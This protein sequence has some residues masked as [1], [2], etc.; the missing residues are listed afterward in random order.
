MPTRVEKRIEQRMRYSFLRLPLLEVVTEQIND[1]FQIGIEQ[2]IVGGIEKWVRG[3]PLHHALV[4]VVFQGFGIIE[5]VPTQTQL[6]SIE[7]GVK[8]PV[9]LSMRV[10][11]AWATGREL[12]NEASTL[13][14]R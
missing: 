6:P 14:I 11:M 1:I 9:H 2:L 12:S 4:K 10:L 5:G 8:Q 13:R 3:K 7:R